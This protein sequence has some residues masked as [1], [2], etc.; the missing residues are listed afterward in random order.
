MD[1]VVTD[2]LLSSIL[3]FSTDPK[4]KFKLLTDD[5]GFSEQIKPLQPIGKGQS[6]SLK[7]EACR[8]CGH[9]SQRLFQ[10]TIKG[11]ECKIN[12]QAL[13][14]TLDG[15]AQ[16]QGVSEPAAVAAGSNRLA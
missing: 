5:S 1:Q 2:S 3:A 13:W 16:T 10:K 9:Y 8:S 15:Q 12:G 6:S 11:F 14:A 4:K 7:P